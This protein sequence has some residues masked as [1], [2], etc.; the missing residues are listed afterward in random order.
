MHRCRIDVFREI[1]VTRLSSGRTDT[2]TCLLTELAQRCTLDIS[3]MAHRD[4]DRI[5]GIEILW[6]EFLARIFD[7][8]AT[9]ISIFLLHLLQFVF[10]HFLAKFRIVK[11]RLQVSNQLLQFLKFLM[12]L[13]DA[14]SCQLRK[15]HVN[16]RFRLQFVK[17]ETFFQIA[18]SIGRCLRRTNDAHHFV[19]IVASNN[20]T[21]QNMCTLL[22][23]LQVELG[24]TDG[25]IMAMFNEIFNA[26]FQCKKARTTFHQSDAI[27]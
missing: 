6:I 27:H 19:N 13:I 9:G 4:N 16:N 15:A 25:Y 1:L 2:T 12:Q 3:E 14:E 26:F 23:F 8:R 22:R 11:N 10:H 17:V 5:I 21:F 20:Q 18:L 24:T 7:F